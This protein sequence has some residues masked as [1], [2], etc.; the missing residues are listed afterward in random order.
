MAT[1]F[2]Q[3][4]H[5]L[6][7]TAPTGG[8]VS[9]TPYKIGQLIVIA[10][11]TAAEGLPFEG[12]T[13]GVWTMPK[14]TGAAWTE[15]ELLYWD[16]SAK[17]VTGTGTSNLLIGVAASAAGSSDATG[18]VRLSGYPRANEAGAG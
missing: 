9:G 4:G 14:A 6:T 16:D 18:V 17:K 1:N 7:L 8:V 2:I 11:G 13:T 3:P 15:G 12:A 10:E 5:V